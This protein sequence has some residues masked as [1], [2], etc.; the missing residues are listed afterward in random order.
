MAK[1]D[2]RD[3]FV[4]EPVGAHNDGLDISGVVTIT[5]PT[6]A[7]KILMQVQTQ[8]ARYTL[9]GTAPSA[10]KGFQIVAGDP[11]KLITFGLYLS[12]SILVCK[13]VSVLHLTTQSYLNPSWYS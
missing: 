10:S 11:E 4:F 3:V 8:N 6:G 9:D 12:Y 1:G 2:Y 13:T 5:I 7:T